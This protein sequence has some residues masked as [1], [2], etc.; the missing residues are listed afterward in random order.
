MNGVILVRAALFL[1]GLLAGTFVGSMML[2]QAAGRL[3]VSDWISYNQAK[4][5]AYGLAM[6][7]FFALTLLASI[8]AA[9]FGAGHRNLMMAA[10]AL[11][12][13]GVITVRIHLPLNAAFKTW[14]RQHHPADSDAIRT[15]WRRWNIARGA[16]A[17]LAFAL[18]I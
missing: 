14:S 11:G 9:I 7:I 4:D 6:P 18:T 10:M 1:E 2:E 5:A 15:R 17:V 3:D 16:L 12:V 13:A 8:V